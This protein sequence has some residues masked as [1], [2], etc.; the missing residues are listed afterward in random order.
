MANEYAVAIHNFISEKVAAAQKN[1]KIA[2]TQKDLASTR[3]CEGRLHELKT[4]RQY[5]TDKID[6]KTQRYY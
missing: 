5:L 3:Y 2:E 4:I 1:K 6:L